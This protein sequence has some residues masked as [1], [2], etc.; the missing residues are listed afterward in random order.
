MGA[1]TNLKERCD[2][3]TRDIE[4]TRRRIQEKAGFLEE[5][6]KPRSLLEPLKRR[7][8]GTLGA[9]GSR[10]LDA[11]R[12]HPLPLALT[13]LG[14]GW[15]L[16]RDLRGVRGHE[17]LSASGGSEG[18]LE[19]AKEAAQSV[20]EKAAGAVEKTREAVHAVREKAAAVPSKVREGARQATDWVSTTL[21]ENP[22]LWAVGALAA[23]VLAGLCVPTSEKEEEDA[24][25]L[26]DKAAEAVLEEVRPDTP[27][28][29]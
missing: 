12:E 4:A 26:V 16:L 1:E 13:G 25:E 5:R 17:C 18:G 29:A 9:G 23:G 6:L 24:G 3:S 2:A 10:I 7:V 21:E 20:R 11:F 28:G 27:P 22:M 19:K 8:E 15:M 14:L